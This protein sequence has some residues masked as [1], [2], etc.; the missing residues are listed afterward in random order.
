MQGNI[1]RREWGVTE[2]SGERTRAKLSFFFPTFSFL[3]FYVFTVFISFKIIT[4]GLNVLLNCTL[5]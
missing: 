4:N 3:F 1:L 2:C 5:T